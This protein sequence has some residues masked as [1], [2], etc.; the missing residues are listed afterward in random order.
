MG[1]PEEVEERKEEG[2]LLIIY[3]AAVNEKAHTS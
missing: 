1:N 3:G 2:E